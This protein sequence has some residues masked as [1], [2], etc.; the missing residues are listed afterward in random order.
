MNIVRRMSRPLDNFF[1]DDFFAPIEDHFN[2]V[3]DNFFE[4]PV[5]DSVKSSFGYP[6]LDASV[7]EDKFI[8]RAAIP[9]STNENINV[10]VLPDGVTVRLSGEMGKE[11]KSEKANYYVKELHKSRFSREFTLPE[12]TK[13]EPTAELKNGILTLT[14]QYDVPQIAKPTKVQIKQIT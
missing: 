8:V 13:G 14:W 11:Y 3:L 1:R 6:K 9:G 10:E 5:L 7:E 4:N 12:G 2:K